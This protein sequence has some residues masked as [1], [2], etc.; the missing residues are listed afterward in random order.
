MAF[1]ILRQIFDAAVQLPGF[2]AGAVDQK[3]LIEQP[4]RQILHH[5]NR[6]GLLLGIVRV[7]LPPEH[8][9]GPAFEVDQQAPAI[10]GPVGLGDA[11]RLQLADHH[12]HRK[13]R[14]IL[15]AFA[16]AGQPV[17]IKTAVMLDQIAPG[18]VKPKRAP[19]QVPGG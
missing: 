16:P 3:R 17:K 13:D 15:N 10:V 2:A 6:I 5:V 7:Q 11:Q 4:H 9:T 18:F 1:E 12:V 19:R 8:H 14:Q